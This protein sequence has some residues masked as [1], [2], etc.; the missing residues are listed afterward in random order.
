MPIV[1]IA[2]DF[3]HV[4]AIRHFALEQSSALEIFTDQLTSNACMIKLGFDMVAIFTYSDNNIITFDIFHSKYPVIKLSIRLYEYD[5]D[6]DV[7]ECLIS[8]GDVYAKIKDF[9]RIKTVSLCD[10]GSMAH[11]PDRCID[12]IKLWFHLPDDRCPI[13]L[14]S[15]GV[16]S[17]L[18]CGH[19][20]HKNCLD[21]MTNSGIHTCAICRRQL[22]DETIHGYP[23]FED[24]TSYDYLK[25]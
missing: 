24:K 19:I 11:E 25:K 1:Q 18:S 3:T 8:K 9:F 14:N 5:G 13:C 15:E 23:F 20:L 6:D 16:W 12:C 2:N 17:K 10:C 21:M 22:D 7:L 4:L